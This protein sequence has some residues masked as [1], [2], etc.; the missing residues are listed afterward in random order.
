MTGD[1][2]KIISSPGYSY[3]CGLIHSEEDGGNEGSQRKPSS[4][5]EIETQPAHND[6]RGWTYKKILLMNLSQ[7]D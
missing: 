5:V 7:P 2:P 6:C 1:Y 3:F 4:Q